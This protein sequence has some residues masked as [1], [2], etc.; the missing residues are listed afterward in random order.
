MEK[1]L[2]PRR[3]PPAHFGASLEGPMMCRQTAE[4]LNFSEDRPGQL[5]DRNRQPDME[6]AAKRALNFTLE[7]GLTTYNRQTALAP[8]HRL[9]A[10][11]IAAETTDA[12]QEI[13]RELARALRGERARMG[14]WSYDLNRHIGLMIAYRSEKARADRILG[15]TDRSSSSKCVG[16]EARPQKGAAP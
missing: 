4:N 16:K 2:I 6:I 14:H 5:A 3:V 1:I 13:L 8:F 10:Q 15:A 7:R 11:T 12:A 9:S